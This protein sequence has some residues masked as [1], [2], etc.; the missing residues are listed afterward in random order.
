MT[1]DEA[2]DLFERRRRAWLAGDLDAYLDL[3]APD[4]IFQSPAHREPLAGRD[5]FAALVRG[6]FAALEPTLFE[7]S[8]VAVHEDLVL[9]EWQLAATH[10]ASGE[11]I[12]WWG[13]S[14]YRIAD[15]RIATWRE[16][17]NPADVA[18]ARRAARCSSRS[19]DSSM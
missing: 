16:Y 13:M 7:F 14:V 2:L 10:R 8:H 9:A 12:A 3:F 17:W 1:R 6:S 5:A 18:G 11:R 4:L 15:G 19:I